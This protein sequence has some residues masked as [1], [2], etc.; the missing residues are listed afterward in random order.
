MGDLSQ[1]YDQAY[2]IGGHQLARDTVKD[3]LKHPH[4]H[5]RLIVWISGDVEQLD[6]KEGSGQEVRELVFRVQWWG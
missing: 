5:V 2:M 4:P 3:S 6:I 1:R